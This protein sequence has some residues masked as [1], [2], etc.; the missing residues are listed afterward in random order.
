LDQGIEPA[1]AAPELRAMVNEGRMISAN[2][3][4][5]IALAALIA[6]LGWIEIARPLGIR[7]SAL[8]SG[9]LTMDTMVRIGILTIVVV[10]LNLLMGYAGQASL[11][12]AAFYGM[13]A[14]AS[15]ILT[16]KA[17]TIGLPV[18]LTTNWWWPW[19][20]M[21][22]SMAFVGAF[23]YLVGRPILR[24]RGH[25]LA[26]ATLG[27]GIM[28]YIIL[29]ENFGFSAAEINITGGS[30]GIPDVGR[31]SIGGFALWPVER[32]Y[33]LVWAVALTVLVL[34]LNIVHSRVGRA[35]RAIRDSEA[36]A[37]A[38]G[39][40]TYRY[41]IQVFA[42]ST[43]YASLAGSLYAH[44]QG[45]VS[46]GPFDFGGSMEL[47]LMSVLG[48]I[49]SIWGA[50]LGVAVTLALKELIRTR[51]HVVLGGS[52]GEQEVIAFGLLIVV[53]MIFMPDGLAVGGVR[54]IRSA[55][56]G[57]PARGQ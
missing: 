28:I 34:S 5:F 23:A 48:G 22:G 57:P 15:A 24:L 39:V 11:G 37:N 27:L 29:R 35:L 8:T 38:M 44:F 26:M 41:K 21:F 4:G 50:P 32:Y 16:V 13:G 56:G 25:Y 12:Q 30:D 46:P 31:L 19:L 45:A 20:V 49:A 2:T 42:L 1:G 7:F 18:G 36:A 14:Y 52:G 10:G 55:L 43:M 9:I 47:V 54:V 33:F 17:R 51:I 6:L 40:D 53:I 3:W